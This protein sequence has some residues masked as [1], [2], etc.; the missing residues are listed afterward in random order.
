MGVTLPGHGYKWSNQ[1]TT[2]EQVTHTNSTWMP[3]EVETATVSV[4]D[5]IDEMPFNKK[6]WYDFDEALGSLAEKF[7]EEHPHGTVAVNGHSIGG[8]MAMHI[9]ISRPTV[10]DRVL[11]QNPG[12][13]SFKSFPLPLGGR[14]EPRTFQHGYFRREMQCETSL[15]Q[16]LLWRLLP[17]QG[18]PHQLCLVT[19]QRLVLQ[20]MANCSVHHDLLVI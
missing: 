17:V 11:V 20:Q 2:E 6:Q 13:R 18:R 10:F 16:G 4:Q 8:L 15:R 19:R 7:K 5:D 3:Y 9:A 14:V 12:N 1:S